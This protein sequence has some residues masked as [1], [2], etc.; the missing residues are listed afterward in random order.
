M[1]IA[2]RELMIENKKRAVEAPNAE[3]AIVPFLPSRVSIK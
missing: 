3:I 1:S 2:V